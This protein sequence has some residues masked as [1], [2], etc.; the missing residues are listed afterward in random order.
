MKIIDELKKKQYAEKIVEDILEIEPATR[1]SDNKLYTRYYEL[2]NLPTDFKTFFNN[3]KQ[4]K[5]YDFK[6]IE[7]ARRK[8]QARRPELKDSTVAEYRFDQQQV[9]FEY[10]RA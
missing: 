9:Y 6:T 7:R 5:A 1:K 3:P 8:I 4:F 10:G 2:L